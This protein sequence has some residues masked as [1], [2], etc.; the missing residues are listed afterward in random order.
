MRKEIKVVKK[1][2]IAKLPKSEVEVFLIFS[3]SKRGTV[4]IFIILISS[5]FVSWFSHITKIDIYKLLPERV[6]EETEI[7]AIKIH[8][9]VNNDIIDSY[10]QKFELYSKKDYLNLL[11]SF[12]PAYS[13]IR[14]ILKSKGFDP[15]FIN[16]LWCE[17]QFRI[18][19]QSHMGAVGPWQF[20]QETAKLVGI[21][22][23][24][25]DERKDIYVSTI[26]FMRHF[27]YLY[28]KF[29]S[30]ELA[31]AAYNCGDGKVKSIISKYNTKNFWDLLKMGAFPRE[32]S[33]YVPKFLAIS[34]W[35]E[36]NE[37]LINKI[38]DSTGSTYYVIKIS[39]QTEESYRLLKDLI[40]KKPFVLKF[41]RH[42]AN[43]KKSHN[44]VN[45]LLDESSLEYLVEN[46]NYESEK[47]SKPVAS[48]IQINF[49]IEKTKMIESMFSSNSSVTK[50]VTT[51]NMP[52]ESPFMH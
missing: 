41:N 44:P 37:P 30:L 2:N 32:T 23:S 50:Q 22:V 16:L 35:A 46:M 8:Y 42:L 45:I 34:K 13:I 52:Y 28:N 15:Q 10:Y 9:P 14:E 4:I 25:I 51:V 24:E 29:G 7:T 11:K 1:K 38:L 36:R 31:I 18:D 26:G 5:L 27:S 17:S 40:N 3:F 20:M 19:A 49:P 39:I 43:L 21:K 48:I 33:Q 6:E 47:N 12:A